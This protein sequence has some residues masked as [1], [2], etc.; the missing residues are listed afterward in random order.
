MESE[1]IVLVGKKSLMAYV[2]AVTIQA[3]KGVDEIIVKA[4]GKAIS[5]AVD[6]AEVALNK[7]LQEWNIKDVVIGTEEVSYTEEQVKKNPELK[8]KKSRVSTIEIKLVKK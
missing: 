1:N 8:G 6:V 2:L 3:G 5:K 4:R 7:F